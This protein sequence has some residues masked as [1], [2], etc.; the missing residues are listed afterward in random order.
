MSEE[1]GNGVYVVHKLYF[2]SRCMIL[3]KCICLLYMCL[4]VC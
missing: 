2:P 3:F 1:E 4:I